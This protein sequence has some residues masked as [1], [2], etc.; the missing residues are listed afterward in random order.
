MQLADQSPDPNIHKERVKAMRKASTVFTN[1][2]K[3]MTETFL[4]H[5][6]V[7][8]KPHHEGWFAAVWKA[9]A[10]EVREQD[11]GKRAKC[12]LTGTAAADNVFCTVTFGPSHKTQA[13]LLCRRLANL[14][15]HIYEIVAMPAKL[16]QLCQEWLRKQKLEYQV[17]SVPLTAA[18]RQQVPTVEMNKLFEKYQRQKIVVAL[19]LE[20]TEQTLI[21]L[22]V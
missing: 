3:Q 21:P 2:L 16:T 5:P 4:S 14:S 17:S 19:F 9:G 18:V 15:Q 6:F 11:K 8:G 7:A 10:L 1:E 20:D 13:R 22:C 12:Y